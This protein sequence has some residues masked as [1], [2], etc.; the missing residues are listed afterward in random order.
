MAAQNINPP[1][2]K[3]LFSYV[4]NRGFPADNLQIP[5]YKKLQRLNVTHLLNQLANLEGDI[6]STSCASPDQLE[7]L[8]KV[9]HHTARPPLLVLL[10]CDS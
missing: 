6:Q 1:Y 5:E 7:P 8:Q 2:G 9:M 4:Q 3:E 10:T